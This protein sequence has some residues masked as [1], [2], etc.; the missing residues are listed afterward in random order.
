MMYSY[1]P[2]TI[3]IHTHTDF[4]TIIFILSRLT[5]TDV[6]LN[7]LDDRDPNYDRISTASVQFDTSVPLSTVRTTPA[8]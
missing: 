2:D 5:F 3:S 6:E 7:E 8:K 1:T 4:V